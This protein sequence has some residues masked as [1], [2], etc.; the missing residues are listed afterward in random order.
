MS[1]NERSVGFAIDMTMPGMRENVALLVLKSRLKL[2]ISWLKNITGATPDA[3]MRYTVR[4]AKEILGIPI[5]KRMTREQLLKLVESELESL[6]NA[7][8]H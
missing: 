1:K 7:P 4:R 8:A 3:D 6:D 5:K 2:E